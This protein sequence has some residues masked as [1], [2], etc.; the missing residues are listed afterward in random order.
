MAILLCI[1]SACDREAEITD[2]PVRDFERRF[3]TVLTH[4]GVDSN[5]DGIISQ[6]EAEACLHLNLHDKGLTDVSGLDAFINLETL[7]CSYNTL[8][9]LDLSKLSKLDWLN[10]KASHL[11]ALDV[12]ACTNLKYLECS[13]NK[14]QHLFLDKHPLLVELYCNNNYD[15]K[16]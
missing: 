9:E 11:I 4:N 3:F 10:C 5:G 16:N 12:S 2:E 15:L 14:I 6:K 7:D 13:Q 8:T 1:I